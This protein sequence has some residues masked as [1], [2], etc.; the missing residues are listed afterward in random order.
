[1]YGLRLIRYCDGYVVGTDERMRKKKAKLSWQSVND[2]CDNI[3]VADE[4]VSSLLF[5]DGMTK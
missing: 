3:I 5:C 2:M 4:L 1:M